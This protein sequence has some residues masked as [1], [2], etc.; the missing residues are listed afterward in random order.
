M[1]AQELKKVAAAKALEFVQ[2]GMRL[3]I[4]SGSTAN[5]FIRLLGER[6]ANGLHVIGVATSHYSEQLCRQVGV[7]VTTLEQIPELDLDI[8]GADEIGPNMTLIKG[9]G[10]ALLREKIVAAASHE[11]L[12]IA[13][14]T[15]VVKTLGAFALPIAV[16]QFGL[17]VTRSAIEKMAKGL[18]LSGKVTL[19]MNGD[20]PFKTDDGHFIFDASWGHIVQPKLL[21]NALFEIPGVIEHGLFVGLASRSIIAM[22]DGQI[23]ILEKKC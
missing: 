5:E 14:E 18:G 16:N 23:K 11:M 13:D 15:K 12:I 6:V 20:N 4:G 17:S 1:N 9:G 3:G 21:S 8:D 22:A 19:R 10:G 7:P 2:D